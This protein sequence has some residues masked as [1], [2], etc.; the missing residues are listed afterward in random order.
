MRTDVKIGMVLSL[1][2]VVAAGWYYLGGD[3]GDEVMP[4]GDQSASSATSPVADAD[5][6]KTIRRDDPANAARGTAPEPTPAETPRLAA[7]LPSSGDEGESRNLR[8]G[9]LAEGEQAEDDP[10]GPGPLADLL[11][12]GRDDETGAPPEPISEPVA[13]DDPSD[14]GTAAETDAADFGSRSGMTRARQ[15]RAPARK[16]GAPSVPKPGSK[17]HVVGRGDSFAILAEVYYGSQRH[18]QQLIEANPQVTDPTRLIVGT[19]LDIPPLAGGV[20][21]QTPRPVAGPGTYVVRSGDTFYGIARDLLGSADRWK[22]LLELNTDVVDGDPMKL[23]PG[24]VLELPEGTTTA[25][26]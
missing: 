7:D 22:E 25:G 10:A 3:S 15:S 4:L 1:V 14:A 6:A 24:Q 17:T 20:P 26:R 18:T 5:T 2:V 16:A 23:R 9:L 19:V 8:G 11:A 21:E 13:S 12:A